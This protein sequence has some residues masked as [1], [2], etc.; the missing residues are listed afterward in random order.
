V[1]GN[2]PSLPPLK[3][4]DAVQK[5][6]GAQIPDRTLLVDGSGGLANAVVFLAAAAKMPPGAESPQAPAV[7]DQRRCEYWPPV[8]ALR[9][10][11]AIEV[12]N[13]DPLLH[14]VHAKDSS[15]LF[16]F[17]MPIQGLKVRKQ[18]PSSPMLIHL[19]CDVHPWMHAVIRTFDH[20][21][22]AIT[23]GSGRYRLAGVPSGR[24]KLVFW[25]QRFP[26]R[27]IVTDALPS[28]PNTAN[29]EWSPSE[30]RL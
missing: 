10:G 21:Y 28:R 17:A 1:G 11:T 20:P 5:V 3:A 6:C 27:T 12:H 29:L 9:A 16:N 19:S 14:N 7:V 26:E 22:F 23:D 8:L 4:S 15:Q 2:I 30:L 24:Q 13:S 18:L 25:H